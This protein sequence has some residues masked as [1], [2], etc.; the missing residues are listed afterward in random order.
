M[1]SLQPLGHAAHLTA[2]LAVVLLLARAGRSAAR[3]LRQPEVIGEIV[4]GLLSGPI[5]LRLLGQDTFDAVLPGS[6]LEALKYVAKA[7]LVLFLVGLAHE[8]RARSGAERRAT[9][10]LAAGSLVPPLFAGALL[11]GFVLLEDDPRCAETPRCPRS[12]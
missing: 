9:L 3:R 7:G 1:D 4:V 5:V 10:W 2:L 11:A 12:Y 8:L 6:A